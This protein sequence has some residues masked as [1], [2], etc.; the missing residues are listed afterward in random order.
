MVPCA[1]RMITKDA[2]ECLLDNVQRLDVPDQV[3][4]RLG[5]LVADKAGVAVARDGAVILVH[6]RGRCCV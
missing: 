4:F 3:G 1:E 6:E 5:R 2:L